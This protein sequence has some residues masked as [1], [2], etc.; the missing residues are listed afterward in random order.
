MRL[1]GKAALITGAGAGIGRESVLAFCR[2]GARVLAVD[3]D[4]A[5]GEETVR[6]ARA[7]G[8]EAVFH[9]ADVSVAAEVEGMIAAAVHAFGRLDVLFNNAGIVLGGTAEDTGEADWDRTMAV[10]LRSAFL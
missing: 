2:E 1:S 8:G 7:P 6:L 4:P 10:N 9:R 5:S 3:R